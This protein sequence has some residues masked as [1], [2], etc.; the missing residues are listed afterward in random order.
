MLICL[1]N[2]ARRLQFN[3]PDALSNSQDQAIELFVSGVCPM[4]YMGSWAIGDIEAKA[5]GNPGFS[6][7]FFLC[8]ATEDPADTIL[9]IQV[10]DAFMVNPNSPNADIAQEFMR[11]WI[12]EGGLTWTEVSS[13]PL[14]SGQSS[15]SLPQVVRDI[16]AIKQTGEYVGYGQYTM[17]YTSE[18]TSAWR[19]G[20][21]EW[22]ENIITGG[23]V[24]SDQQ[25][26][27]IQQLFDDIRALN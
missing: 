19:R 21:T 3:R 24:T 13:Q 22:A 20:L 25:I 23:S 6:Y 17:A 15:D 18:Y 16:A 14:I 27:R 26:A 9:Q 7:G 2:W 5:A 12:T 8:P 11:Y 4:M 10:D 1:L